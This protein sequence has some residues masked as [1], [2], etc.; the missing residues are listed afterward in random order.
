[1]P[2]QNFSCRQATPDDVAFLLKLRE[3]TMSAQM[4]KAGI[5]LSANDELARVVH[6]FECAEIVLEAGTPVGLIKVDRGENNWEIIQLQL[7]P[8]SQ[9]KGVGSWL[10][11]QVIQGAKSAN[12]S[13]TLSVLKDNPAKRLY[14]SL[15]F[16]V[17]GSD[18]HEYFMIFVT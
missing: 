17:T 5:G 16:V 6:K 15:G 14:Q 9:G 3:S 18:D 12:A 13:L 8:S 1:M 10:V 2:K 11:R 4:A 7:C